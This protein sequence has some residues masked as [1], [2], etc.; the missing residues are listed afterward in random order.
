MAHHGHYT[1]HYCTSTSHTMI[2]LNNKDAMRPHHVALNKHCIQHVACST[3]TCKMSAI[4]NGNH[5]KPHGTGNVHCGTA[6]TPR[7][8]RHACHTHH[9]G[10]AYTCTAYRHTLRTQWTQLTRRAKTAVQHKN[11]LLHSIHVIHTPLLL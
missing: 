2:P 1:P 7:T 8:A 5:H 9:E 10:I 6:L 11:H 4:N 3:N